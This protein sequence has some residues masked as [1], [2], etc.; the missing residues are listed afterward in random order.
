MSIPGFAIRRSVTIYMACAV[1]ILLGAISFER[2]PVDL[3]PDIEYPR[4]SVNTTYQGAAPEEIEQLIS[5]RIENAVGSAPGV[6]EVESTSSE[7]Q[8]RVFISFVWG[9]DVD[10]AANEVRTRLDRIRSQLPEGADS[11]RM[12]KFDVSQFPILFLAV[13]GNMGPRELR[14]FTEDQIQYRIERVPGVGQAEVQGG[15]RRQIQVNLELEKLR[16][17]D[18]S[19]NQVVSLLQREN[20]NLPAGTVEEGRFD[21]LL[22]TRG[23]FQNLQQIQ[24]LVLTTRGG[25]PVYLRDVAGIVDGSEEVLQLNR[26]NGR[27]GVGIRVQKQSGANTV[28]VAD[29]VRAEIA[30]IQQDFPDLSI[31]IMRDSSAFIQRSIA[32]VEEHAAVGGLLAVFILLFFLR[33]VGSTLIVSLAIPI[34]LV[35]TFGLLYFFGYTLNTVTLGGLAL[36]VGRLVDDAIVVMENTF[37]HRE[38]G[39]SRKDA[40]LVGSQ[41]VGTAII[42]S[43]LTTIVVFLPIAFVSGVTSVLFSQLAIT[44][45]FALFCSLMVALTLI[46]VLCSRYLKVEPPSAE[47]HPWMRVAV[48]GT[49]RFLTLLDDKYQRSV[50]WALAHRKTVIAGALASVVATFFLVPFIGVELLPETDEGEVNVN[51]ELPA[52]SRLEVTDEVVQ[53]MEDVI[54]DN[55]PELQ[56]LIV[57]VGNQGGGGPG[58]GAGGHTGQISLRLVDREDRSRS[59]QEIAASLN[60]LLGG[61]PGVNVRV[62][63]SSGMH[64][65]GMRGLSGG[66]RASVEIRGYNL[67][68]GNDLA[69]RIQQQVQTIP[70]VTNVRISRTEGLPEMLIEVDRVKAALLGLNVNELGGVLETAVAGR[71]AGLYREEGHEY[72]IV[73]RLREADRTRLQSVDLIPVSTPL[74]GTVPVGSLVSRQRQEGP[75]AIQRDDR[76]RVITISVGFFGRDLGSVMRDIQAKVDPFRAELPLNFAIL[77]GG[78]YEQQQESF[79]QLIF[80]LLLAVLLVYMVLAA[81]YESWRDPL[82]ILF[83]IPLAGVGVALTLLLTGTNLSIQAFLGIIMLSGIAVSNAILLVDYTNLLRRRDGLSVFDAVT[84]AGRRRLRPILMTTATTV[85][86][87]LP[88]ALGFGEGGEVQAPMA[89][90][91]IGGLITSTAITLLFVPTLYAIAEERSERRAVQRR[92]GASLDDPLSATHGD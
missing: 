78:E 83:S 43:T 68:Y 57:S 12:F 2:L 9:T 86:G 25:V 45:V 50:G 84:L 71:T 92:Q 66:E 48:E 11:P 81:Q 49:G 30:R 63:A 85:L 55:V 77:Y 1:A 7:N 21:L 76:E 62:N 10:E 28:A 14:E 24:N 51:V 6:E 39:K 23:Q 27:P 34:S 73:V 15:L 37:R 35:S 36:G 53:R 89:R 42:A 74:G 47:R 54:T 5:R 38:M 82:I 32:T 90:V 75:V 59:S 44:V 69:R 31:T 61:V 46:P 17:L 13:S 72:D 87:L 56:G 8:S 22:R 20:T 40:A 91:V 3:M 80:A 64:L 65:P 60:D 4:I 29:G 33:N 41:E 16:S 70:S 26:V 52:G 67:T 88:M 79:R 58:R 19:V 18:L